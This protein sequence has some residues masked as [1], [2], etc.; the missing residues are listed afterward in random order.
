MIERKIGLWST[1]QGFLKAALANNAMT[2]KVGVNTLVS[3][4]VNSKYK[5]EG[6]LNAANDLIDVKGWAPNPVF[7]D[8]L[9]E[10]AYSDYKD[11]GGVRFPGHI[12][13]SQGG[14]PALD[15]TV[16]AVRLNG[17]GFH[18]ERLGRLHDFFGAIG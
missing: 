10:T 4:T 14:Q 7:G 15:I 12:V 5:L 1:P 11:F 3:F 13:Q 16:S 17:E 2:R 9:I 18:P 6:T 8:M